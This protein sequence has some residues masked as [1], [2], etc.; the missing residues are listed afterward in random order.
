VATIPLGFCQ[1][2]AEPMLHPPEQHTRVHPLEK[3]AR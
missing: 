1:H 2:L 3:P